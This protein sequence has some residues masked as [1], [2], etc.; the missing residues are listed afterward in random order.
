MTIAT[1]EATVRERLRTLAAAGE[2]AARYPEIPQIL[3]TAGPEEIAAAGRQLS[4]LKPEE[5]IALHPGTDT[6]TVAVT[7]SSTLGGLLPALTGELARH[8][9]LLRPWV[10]DFDGWITE[11]QDTDSE[12]YQAKADLTL[13]VLDAAAV[14]RSLPTPWQAADAAAATAATLAQ[15][16]RLAAHY[17]EHGTGTLV[18]NTVPLL[19]G[20][21]HQLVDLASRAQLGIT[22]R[23]FNAGLLKLA[24]KYDRVAVLDLEPLLAE[25][26][27][28]NDPRLAVYAKAEYGDELLG[29]YAREVGHLARTVKGRTKKVLV[30]DLDNTLWDGILGDDGADGIAAAVTFR[31]EAFGRFQQVVKQIGSQGVLLA[32]SSKN[33]QEP[34]VDVLTSHPDMVLRAADFVRIN[35]NW[36]P[37]DAN[38]QDIAQRLNLGV[39]SFVFADDSSFETGLVASSLPSVAVIRLDEEPALHVAKLLA[40]NWFDVRELTAEDRARA[41][42]YRSEE[43]RQTLLEST[44]SMEEYLAQLEVVV[45]LSPVQEH[46]IARLAQLTLRTNQFNLTTERLQVADVRER[47]AD[48]SHLVLAVRTADRFGDQGLV[49]GVFAHTEGDALAIDNVILSCRVFS[50]GIEQTAIATVLAE[51]ARRGLRRVTASYRPTKKN[52]KVREFYPSVGFARAGGTDEEPDFAHDLAER[53]EVPGH[54]RVAARF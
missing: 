38:L 19:R 54:V 16:D 1:H 41:G 3:A 47:L 2:L 40:D 39:D 10:G 21:T 14:L 34:V 5:V 45:D 7:G 42:L 49:G 12:L 13:C 32:V 9:L 26:G 37:K 30:V 36:Q 35:A 25:S 28:V 15:L 31:G 51:A 6:F 50:R 18:L 44:G 11:L 23:E 53:L 43:A 20:W 8:G 29:R 27:P 22:W 46:E 48:D 17:L 52:H 33:D 4:R 24:A